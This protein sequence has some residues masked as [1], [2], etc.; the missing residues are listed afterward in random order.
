MKRAVV[1][2]S[3][4]G[5]ATVAREL[6]G[7]FDVT[8]L[9]AGGAFRPLALSMGLM[10][11]LKRLGLLFDERTIRLP[12]PA[13]RVSKTREGMALVR[14]V[15][16]G[17]ST[18]V[19]T[20]NA[21][22]LDAGLKRIGIDLDPEFAWI[23][24]EIPI[25]TEHR[26]RWRPATRRLFDICDEM[27]LEPRPTPKMGD[28]GRCTNCGR[29]VL[30]CR[31]GVKWDT[32]RFLDDAVARGARLVSG[33]AAERVVIEGGKTTGVV[34]RQGLRRRFLP[35]DLVV[36]AAGGFAT[37]T[38][39]GRSGIACEPRLFVDPVLCVAAH[40]P[41]SL[42]SRELAMPFYVARDHYMLSPYLDYLSL[43]FNR[44]WR[45]PA[46]DTLSLMIKLADESVGSVAGGRIDKPL[47]QTDRRRLDEAVALCRDILEGFGVRRE[48]T[49]LGTLNAGH[50]GGS[51]PLTEAEAESLHHER[52]PA[53]LYLADATLIPEALG[54]PP[55][56]TIIAIAK[57]VSRLCTERLA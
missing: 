43:F 17:G 16:L 46:R 50:P 12:F 38:I 5:G 40:W 31:H 48:D 22:R 57:R 36:V 6:Q 41:G 44:R 19:S 45:Y 13:M 37:P 18:A 8:V 51:L 10:E 25:G 34:A 33:C 1:V 47:T 27:G 2:G 28:Y 35:A 42:Q 11:R 15:G 9:E 55:I 21:L 30:G 54:G 23:E 39:L 32:R 52:L 26:R 3:G 49:F 7:A 20:G 53:N 24:R 56:L 29:C 14:G 4:A